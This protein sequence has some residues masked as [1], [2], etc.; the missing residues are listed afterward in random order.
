L[1][2]QP[3]VAMAAELVLLA[4]AAWEA[5]R[6]RSSG[7]PSPGEPRSWIT[8]FL[9]ASLLL[10]MVLATAA[11]TDTWTAIPHGNWD[12]WSIWNLRARF[13]ASGHFASG[14]WSPVLAQYTR[15]EYPLLVS[16]FVG[17]CWAFG[18]AGST[19]IPAAA[20][21]LFFLALVSLVSGGIMAMRGVA[22]G[23]LSA[24]VL[25]VTPSLLR[26]VPAQY[27]DIPVACYM[28]GA[29]VFLLLDQPWLAGIFAG[30]AAWTKDE[31]M[32]FLIV[33][34][35]LTAV[36][37]RRAVFA[38]LAGAVPLTALELI[39]RATATRGIPSQLSSSLPG[40][41]HRIA[42]WSR[43]SVVLSA[44]GRE[45]GNMGIGWYHPL[46]PLIVLAIALRFDRQRRADITISFAV[47]ATLLMAYF[48]VYIVT[49]L[50]LAWQLQTSL[51]RVLMQA[52]PLLVLATFAGLNR[53]EVIPAP[54][55]VSVKAARRASAR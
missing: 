3:L 25:A 24:L 28:V 6:F 30:F 22:V 36:L 27:A 39:F 10:A 31:G 49:S 7:A 46:L 15:A 43:Y 48:G 52:W 23:L 44:W 34:L 41:P 11:M 54:V 19:A 53:F 35:A 32:L 4:W 33:L 16:S 8:V 20:S 51:P 5:W 37:K 42:E 45:I 12:A 17:R 1:F 21:Y 9:W 29:M 26:E 2:R 50:D 38:V 14:A 47:A 55:K 18:H 40:A 13:L